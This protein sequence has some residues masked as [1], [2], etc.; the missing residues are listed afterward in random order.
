[1][2]VTCPECGGA[3]WEL[4]EGRFPHFR[5]HVGHG[6]SPEAFESAQAARVETAL[7][8]ALRALEENAAFKRGMAERARGCGLAALAGGYEQQA[9]EVERQ[10]AVVREALSPRTSGARSETFSNS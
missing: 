10:A 3:L 8:T 7:W 1:M 4:R 5:C 2:P 6:F 9:T